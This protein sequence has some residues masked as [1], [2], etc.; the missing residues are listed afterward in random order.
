[1]SLLGS[2][3]FRVNPEL[4]ECYKMRGWYDSEGGNIDANNISTKTGAG[5]FNTP[6]M[7][8]KEVQDQQLGNA[9]KG[10]YYQVMGTVLLMRGENLIYKACPM[11]KC[12]KKIVDLETGMYRC[13][14]CRTEY[15]N[16]KYRLLGS[17][18]TCLGC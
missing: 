17:V 4:S 7:S 10:D 18:S 14:K 13:E 16:F 2:S 3:Q 9:E 1:M 11:E 15:P 8:F 6:W 12:N 5:S